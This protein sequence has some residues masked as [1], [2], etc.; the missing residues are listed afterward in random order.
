M[1]EPEEEAAEVSEAEAAT[2]S[3]AAA[4]SSSSSSS[5]TNLAWE[6]FKLVKFGWYWGRMTGGEAERKKCS[7]CEWPGARSSMPLRRTG[8]YEAL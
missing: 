4:V 8:E 2:G 1:H 3:P 7:T 6:L 5:N